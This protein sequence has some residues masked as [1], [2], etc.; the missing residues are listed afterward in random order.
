MRFTSPVFLVFF[1]LVYVL[2]WSVPR[3]RFRLALLYVGSLVFYAMWSLPF[4]AHFLFMLGLNYELVRSLAAARRRGDGRLW[5]GIILVL[6]FGNLFFFKYSHAFL[7]LWIDAGLGSAAV[8]PAL[9]FTESMVLPLAISF[10][11]FQM[12]AFA[13]DVYRREVPALPGYFDYAVFILFF[14]QLV[15][16][17]IM[18]HGDFL[19]QLQRLDQLRPPPERTTGGMYLLMQGLTK[20]ILI[21]DNLALHTVPVFYD[22]GGYDAGT[23]LIA[24][25]GYAAQLYCDF[26]GYTD[27]ARGL[28]KLLG[29]ELPENFRGPYLNTSIRDFWQ[30]WHITLTAWIRDYVYI[31]LGGNRVS[32]LRRA[33]NT[34]FTLLLIG[35]WHGA[36]YNFFALGLVNGLLLIGEDWLAG[37]VRSAA[38]LVGLSVPEHGLVRSVLTIAQVMITF[39]I[40]ALVMIML[41]TPDFS[42]TLLVY[43][44]IFTLAGGNSSE[45]VNEIFP[46]LIVFTFVLNGLQRPIWFSNVKDRPPGPENRTIGQAVADSLSPRTRLLA[47]WILG[48]ALLL[49]LGRFAPQGADFIY[50]QF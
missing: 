23:L 50:F 38:R 24:T 4:G 28:G 41:I 21:A 10:Y 36:G 11:T 47:L 7:Q 44:R 48:L 25:F 3:R 30:T 8:S 39:S 42:H 5:L 27:I 45:A 14:P 46:L 9:S 17:P 18:R 43:R 34:V 1:L 6:N 49:A 33:F 31:P 20:K 37:V 29:L 22:P 15:A 2:F 26:S 16:G 12:T 13:V 40:V 32:M 35:I 19:G